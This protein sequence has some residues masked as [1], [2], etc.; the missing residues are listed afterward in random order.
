MLMR[1]CNQQEQ[2]TKYLSYDDTNIL[3]ETEKLKKEN[4]YAQLGKLSERIIRGFDRVAAVYDTR[5]AAN[6]KDK[7]YHT[8]G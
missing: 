3:Y 2:I 8:C 6:G 5:R 4:Q 1:I 7:D